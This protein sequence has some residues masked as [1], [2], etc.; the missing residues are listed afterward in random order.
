MK[1][2]ANQTTAYPILS[3]CAIIVLSGCASLEQA[4]TPRIEDYL[5]ERARQ[6]ESVEVDESSLVTR[7]SVSQQ[8]T[9]K[10]CVDVALDRNPLQAAAEAGLLAAGEAVGEARAPYYPQLALQSGYHHWERHAFLPDGFSAPQVNLGGGGGSGMTTT[11]G[12]TDD[13]NAGLVA[14]LVLFD[15]GERRA[16]LRA[17]LARQGMARED[18]KRVRQDV[19]FEVHQ[20]FYALS[21]ALE[22][23]E[24]AAANLSRSEEHLRLAKV[25]KSM[26]AVPQSDV[27]RAQ[28]DLAQSRLSLIQANSLVQISRGNLN[29]AMGLPVEMVM[30][31]S[32]E[33][34]PIVSPETIALSDAMDEAVHARPELASGLKKIEAGRHT[35]SAARSAYGPKI[36]A[37]GGYGWRDE[38][39]LPEDEDWSVGFTSEIPL[40][41]GHATK[42][43]VARSKAELARH[44]AE[45][46][47]LVLA[48]RNEVWAAYAE[49]GKS[50]ETIHASTAFAEDARESLRLIRARYELGG[51]TINDLLDTQTA[52]ARAEANLVTSQW[53]YFRAMSVFR[54]ATGELLQLAEQ[55]D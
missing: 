18:L 46:R 5:P 9:L 3:L 49:L 2:T 43:K 32:L 12:P 37:E 55:D 38:K 54:R 27:V 33:P 47:H 25:R 4:A 19:A 24:V 28:T 13:W 45:V 52:F 11:I 22:N 35:V 14:S 7:P 20:T 41:T 53:D 51:A 29:T 31:P 36:R 6:A 34:E 15:S 44:E 26:G 8:L 39:F 50:Y 21:S 48:V 17:A 16:H 40:F 42:H 1:N 23:H 10:T 30:E